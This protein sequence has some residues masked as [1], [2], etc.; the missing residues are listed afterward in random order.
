[1]SSVGA[2][3]VVNPKRWELDSPADFDLKPGL[4]TES[5]LSKGDFAFTV[6]GDT[7]DN[8]ILQAAYAPNV[9]GAGSIIALGDQASNARGVAFRNLT[10]RHG[11]T[12]RRWRTRAGQSGVSLLTGEAIGAGT[13]PCGLGGNTAD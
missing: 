11:N 3:L 8:T 6:T 9:P 5:G 12:G 7:R 10:L 13:R 2:R 1:M 4:Y